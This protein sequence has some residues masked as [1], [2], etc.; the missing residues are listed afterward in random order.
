MIT[1]NISGCCKDCPH[2]DLELIFERIGSWKIYKDC[3]CA[4]ECVCPN[5]A[6][7]KAKE[8]QNDN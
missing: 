6:R 4:H 3:H 8:V 5:Y 2:I 7:E 1:L